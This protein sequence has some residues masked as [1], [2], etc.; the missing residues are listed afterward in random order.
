[1][2][3]IGEYVQVHAAREANPIAIYLKAFSTTT[4]PIPSSKPASVQVRVSMFL[5]DPKERSRLV[6][7]L[8]KAADHI[9]QEGNP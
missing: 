4:S 9:E 6:N 7:D 2:R 8:R 3:Y 1:M 5:E